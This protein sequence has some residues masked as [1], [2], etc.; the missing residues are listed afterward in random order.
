MGFKGSGTRCLLN[1]GLWIEDPLSL[2]SSPASASSSNI[3]SNHRSSGSSTS[4]IGHC[5][6][7]NNQL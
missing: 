4:M 1:T 7:N 5:S 2:S 6:S 3:Y